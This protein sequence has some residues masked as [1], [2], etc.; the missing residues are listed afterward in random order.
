LIKSKI[1]NN[2]YVAKK[3]L[4]GSLNQK[5]VEGAHLEVTIQMQYLSKGRPSEGT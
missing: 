4:L 3:V 2:I 1:D 5:E